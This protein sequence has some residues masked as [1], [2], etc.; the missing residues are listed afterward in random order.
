MIASTKM[1]IV[2]PPE[3]GFG[4]V[5]S[6][7][8]CGGVGESF[9]G[10]EEALSGGVGV[11]GAFRGDVDGLVCSPV[12]GFA[13]AGG[14]SVVGSGSTGATGTFFAGPSGVSLGVSPVAS[15]SIEVEGG[16]GGVS[17]GAMEGVAVG[18][19]RGEDRA[20]AV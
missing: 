4:A 18:G 14:E 13:G 16:G 9:A 7:L 8:D 17:G 2:L 3:A 15:P 6:A 1:V 10:G 12:L 20:G 5:F 19:E 11:A